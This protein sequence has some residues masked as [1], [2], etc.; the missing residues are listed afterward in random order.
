MG[1][2]S[3]PTRTGINPKDAAPAALVA[4]AFL[5]AS[6]VLNFIAFP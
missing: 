2:K 4:P 6:G 1:C 3:V 5:A